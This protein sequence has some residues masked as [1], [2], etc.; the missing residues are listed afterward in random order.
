METQHTVSNAFPMDWL[1]NKKLKLLKKQN[2]IFSSSF[3]VAAPI[4]IIEKGCFFTQNLM[5]SLA[6]YSILPGFAFHLLLTFVGILFNGRTNHY[7][8]KDRGAAQLS[9]FIRYNGQIVS[10]FKSLVGA[11]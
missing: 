1:L 6:F 4:V 9:E 10:I 7:I 8:K 5:H 2:I 11:R 3:E